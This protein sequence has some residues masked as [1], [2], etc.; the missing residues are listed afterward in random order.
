[1]LSI[2]T[3]IIFEFIESTRIQHSAHPPLPFGDG[4]S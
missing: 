1:L 3:K 4:L 2:V